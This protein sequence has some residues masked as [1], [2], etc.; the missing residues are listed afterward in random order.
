VS[1]EQSLE[2]PSPARYSPG[3]SLAIDL[4]ESPGAHRVQTPMCRNT[5]PTPKGVCKSYV[6]LTFDSD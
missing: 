3:G 4:L 2:A 5:K 6:D 1:P